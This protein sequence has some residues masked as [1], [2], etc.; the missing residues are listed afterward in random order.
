MIDKEFGT[1]LL[2]FTTVVCTLLHADQ[3]QAESNSISMNRAVHIRSPLARV[4]YTKHIQGHFDRSKVESY[5]YKWY[6]CN[7]ELFTNEIKKMFVRSHKDDETNKFLDGCY[8]QSDWVFTQL[9]KAIAKTFLSLFM[10]QTTINGLLQRGSMFVCSSEQFRTLA[11]IDKNWKASSMLDL[12]AGDGMVTKYLAPHFQEVIV[13]E[14]STTMQWRLQEKGYKVVGVDEWA[15]R[16]YDMISCLNLI[17]RCDK[18]ITLLHNIHKALNPGGIVILAVVIPYRPFV[19]F[20]SSKNC[21]SE[22][23]E[24]EGKTWEEQAQS[25]ITEYFIPAGFKL[26]SFT[27]VPYLCEGDMHNPFYVLSDALFVLESS[28]ISCEVQSCSGQP[29]EKMIYEQS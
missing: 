10:S 28:E 25:L 27:R 20:G 19:E 14:M 11:S 7:D 5:A 24:V 17:D 6:E 16:T 15:N 18:P 21:P 3:A 23:M 8:E 22:Y 4:M 12:G 29:T 9:S 26:R 2:F 13:T 1:L